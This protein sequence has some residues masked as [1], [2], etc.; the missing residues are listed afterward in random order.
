EVPGVPAVAEPPAF[1]SEV[2]LVPPLQLGGRRQRLLVGVLAAD[3]VA[4]HGYERLASLWPER[5][6]DVCS[7]RPPIKAGKDR[8]IDFQHIHQ[9][10]GIE[11]QG[12][13]LAVANRLVGKKRGGAIA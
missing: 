10:N 4:A 11:R 9:C 3:Q 5:R 12:R 2:V 7:S 1:G 13:G 8:T 6:D